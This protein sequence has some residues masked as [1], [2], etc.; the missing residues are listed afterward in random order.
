L[1]KKVTPGATLRTHEEI[2]RFFTGLELV[3]PGLVQV[4]YWRPEEPEPPDADK[5]AYAKPGTVQES[6]QVRRP[7]EASFA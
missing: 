2:L 7:P 6:L 3:E 1:Y 4:P 5:E